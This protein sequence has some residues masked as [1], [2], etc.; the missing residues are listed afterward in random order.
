MVALRR[1]DW[2]VVQRD[3]LLAASVP[4]PVCHQ[5]VRN[6]VQPGGKGN[7]PVSV[8][9][10]MVHRPLKNTGCQVLCIVSVARTVVNV[11]EDSLQVSP[12]ELTE[13]I[14]IALR[15]ACKDLL[16]V[17]FQ[18]GQVDYPTDGIY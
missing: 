13:C 1:Q 3:F 5:V 10:Y 12:I 11:V 15:G 17:V 2:Q 6:P 16:F 7:A 4:V 14:A 8:I 9:P 18:I